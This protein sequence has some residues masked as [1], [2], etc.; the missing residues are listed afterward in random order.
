M[1]KGN[2]RLGSIKL[3]CMRVSDYRPELV[4]TG[5]T[6]AP[7]SECGVACWVSPT[8]FETISKTPMLCNHCV[9][10]YRVDVTVVTQETVREAIKTL[11][12]ERLKK[13]KRRGG[14]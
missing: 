10:G 4:P 7:C 14:N 8:S 2:K 3:V 9:R 12:R 6:Q 1:S 5:A 13:K 11:D